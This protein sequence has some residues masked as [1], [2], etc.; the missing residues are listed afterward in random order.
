MKN[1]LWLFV[2]PVIALTMISLQKSSDVKKEFAEYVKLNDTLWASR[3]EVTNWEY[4]EFLSSLKIKGDN[5]L[6]AA[7]LYDS[8]QWD[9]KFP[10]A[11]NEPMKDHYHFHP[12][13]DRYP[14]VNISLKAAEA[15][16]SWLTLQYSTQ[17]KRDHKKVIFR[18]PTEQEWILLSSPL[19]G[20]NLPWYGNFPYVDPEGKTMLTNIKVKCSVSGYNDYIFDGGFHTLMVGHYK[21][22]NLGLYDVV[23]NVSEMTRDG[24]LKGGSWDN[25]LHECTIDKSQLYTLPDPRVGFRVIMEVEE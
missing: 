4:R 23:G 19:P 12:A 5:D 22:N 7:C 20:H 16:C 1:R 11:Y 25:Y 21:P 14:V 10:N 9:K 13:Y 17:P 2:L 6:Y 3:F 8:T 24:I 18:L 15:Y